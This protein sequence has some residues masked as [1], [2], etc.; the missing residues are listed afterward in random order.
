MTKPECRKN[1]DDHIKMLQ[2]REK[3][4][5]ANI[6]K[7]LGE[8]DRLKSTIQQVEEI[9]SEKADDQNRSENTLRW[10]AQWNNEKEVSSDEPLNLCTSEGKS[11]WRPYLDQTR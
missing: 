3:I 8:V 2:D 9:H 10:L 1:E 5:D 6:E 7:L 4:L 11:I